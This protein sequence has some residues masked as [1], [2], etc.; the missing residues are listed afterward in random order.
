M[1]KYPK[2]RSVKPLERKRLLVTFEN[3]IQKI[4][5]CNPILQEEVFSPLKNV[6]FN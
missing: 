4:Y 5:D 2:I 1:A 6:A 3:N